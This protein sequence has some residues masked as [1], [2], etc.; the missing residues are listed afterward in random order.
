MKR[1]YNQL[2]DRYYNE[3]NEDRKN[4]LKEK[5]YQKYSIN[6][7]CKKCAKQLLISYLKEYKY[8][9]LECEENFYE[10]ET[11]NRK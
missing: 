8:L 3:E 9:C 5:I 6:R 7:Y 2:L 10:F 11:I 1:R 4:Q